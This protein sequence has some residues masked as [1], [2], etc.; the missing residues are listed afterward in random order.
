MFLSLNTLKTADSTKLS[1]SQTPNKS[2]S[3]DALP[4]RRQG[5]D[6]EILHCLGFRHQGLEVRG[7]GFEFLV[8]VQERWIYADVPQLYSS[9]GAAPILSG[10]PSLRSSQLW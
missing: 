1:L 9:F 6:V 2:R 10:D 4:F 8:I 3:T 5:L 7:L